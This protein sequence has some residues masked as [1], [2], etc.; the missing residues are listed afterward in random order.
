[1]PPRTSGGPNLIR[2]PH[3]PDL[4]F[5]GR[6]EEAPVFRK[7]AIDAKVTVIMPH[8]D[9]P[10]GASTRS[11]GGGMGKEDHALRLIGE[12]ENLALPPRSLVAPAE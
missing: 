5:G 2:R 1:M 8:S 7:K 10:R 11:A 4:M 3:E 6:T 9:G 12:I